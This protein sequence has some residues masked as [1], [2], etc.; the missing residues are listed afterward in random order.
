MSDIKDLIQFRLSPGGMSPD[1]I[2][3]SLDPCDRVA[4]EAC[5]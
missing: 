4:G 1:C 2:N 3:G 5:R